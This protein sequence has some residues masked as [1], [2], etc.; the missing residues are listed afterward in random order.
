MA[1]DETPIHVR[2]YFGGFILETLTV[3]MYG[4]SRNAIREYL[5]NSFD[6][7]RRAIDMKILA[8]DEGRIEIKL[9]EGHKSLT[10]R[11]NGA[12]IRADLATDVLTRVGASTKDHRRNAG[13]RGIGR[14]AGIVFSDTVTFVTKAK[15]EGKQ[16][17]VI[18]DAKAMRELMAPEQGSN[19]SATEVMTKTVTA[20]TSRTR[21]RDKH[22]FE[23][24]LD[25]L[26][27]PPEECRSLLAMTAFVSQVAPVPFAE[28]FAYL[29][30]L[31]K[32]AEAAKIPIEHV[33][34]LIRDG[35]GAAKPVYKPYRRE[36]RLGSA[37][38]AMSDCEVCTSKS[39]NW[40]A[41]V[42]KKLESGAYT[43]EQVAGLRVRVRNI[44]ID[45]TDLIREVFRKRAASHARFQDYFIGEVY[46]RPG[47]LIPNARRDGFEEDRA[48]RTFV[49]E[50]SVVTRRLSA[51][52]YQISRQGRFSVD[53]LKTEVSETRK[54][55]NSLR[56]SEFADVDRTIAFSKKIT[57]IQGR[58][59]K[60]LLG[61]TVEA[62]GQL[63]V[64]GSELID[65]KRETLSYLGATAFDEDRERLQEETREEM[66]EEILVLFEDRLSPSCFSAARKILLDEYGMGE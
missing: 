22:F 47:I 8:V 17:T 44:Q 5:Q 56:K 1:N 57:T 15:D 23:V 3:G 6:S 37:T 24:K 58:I 64:L 2:P 29:D 34:I 25:G 50:L 26:R 66:I 31:Q 49:Q 4:E 16:T 51:E 46:V 55:F 53:A 14:L 19:L 28:E 20:H 12:G 32:M 13:F 38:V 48:W 10:I 62:A 59:A 65:M 18:I 39:G 40:W 11:D 33:N 42:G 43:D 35:R 36:H 60:S 54:V 21:R 61:S 41:W 7:I 9:A 45:G 63:H 52:A 30:R 27:R